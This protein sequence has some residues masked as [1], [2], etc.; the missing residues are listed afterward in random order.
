MSRPSFQFYPADWRN[1]AK[2]RRC[3]WEARG[4]WLEI[5]CLL[6]DS[7]EYGILRWNLKEIA[8][9]IGAPKKLINE[10]VSKGVL[11]GSDT[12]HSGLIYTPVSGRQQGAPVTLIEATEKPIWYSSRMVT[13]EYKRKARGKN[14]RF[15][16][17][18][19]SAKTDDLTAPKA[20]PNP[21]PKGG[22]GENKGEDIGASPNTTPSRLESDGSSSSSSSSIYTLP[23]GNVQK[24]D[25]Q[26]V[27]NAAAPPV[28]LCPHDS[29]I[30]LYHECLPALPRIRDW[31]PARQQALRARWREKPERQNLDWWRKFFGYVAQS[32]FLT[33]KVTR[34]GRRPFVA[35]LDWLCKAENFAK[36]I[37]GR[38]ENDPTEEVAHG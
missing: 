6:H 14:S 16:A 5:M 12:Q 30:E 2:L 36:V 15:G 8:Q 32:D 17:G 9:A 29:I 11:K 28:N 10:L 3:S 31:T 37:E 1:N 20:S 34:N 25:K 7:E 24:P 35:S 18:D 27:A 26:V 38:Y 13:D 22:F 19:T 23:K 33:G 21:S 4:A